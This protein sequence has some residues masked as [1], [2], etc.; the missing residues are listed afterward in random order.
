LARVLS[1][2]DLTPDADTVTLF[3]V[4][5]AD[6]GEDVRLTYAQD[7]AWQRLGYRIAM[8]L[9]ESAPLHLFPY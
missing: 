4:P 9:T 8:L 1:M 5:E 7:E 3:A 6:D 2:V